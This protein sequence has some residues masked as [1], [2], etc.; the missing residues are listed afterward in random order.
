[1]TKDITELRKEN[2]LIDL[3]C[4]LAEIPSPSGEEDKVS[5]KIVEILTKAGI[6]AKEDHFKNVRAKIPATNPNK[7]PLL[8]SAHMDVVGDASPVNMRISADGKFI[9]TDKS[10][11]LGA[12]DKVGDAAAIYLALNLVKNPDMV[13]GGH[14]GLELVFTKDEE[15]NMTGIHNVKFDEIDSEYVLVLDADK[16]GQI[17]ISGA[18]YTNE[19]KH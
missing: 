19:I 6:D 5:A 18:S 1:M 15:Q 2:E 11:P 12:D 13:Q 14:G 3:F 7:K 4:T 8:L 17:Q 10:R 9:E 16:L